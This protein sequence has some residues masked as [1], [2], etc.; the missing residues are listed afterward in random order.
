[1]LKFEE[2][3]DLKNYRDRIELMRSPEPQA[4]RT[5]RDVPFE[6]PHLGNQIYLDHAANTIYMSSLIRSYHERLVSHTNAAT[7]SLFS[8]PHSQSQSGQ[9]TGSLVDATREKILTYLLDTNSSEY[10]LVFV[11]NATAGLK[12][13]GECVRPGCLAYLADNHTSAI[14]MRELTESN[15]DVYCISSNNDH[16]DNDNDDDNLIF[17]LINKSHAENNM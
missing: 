15:A 5:T 4:N 8:N 13:L 3:Y 6:F 16:S 2:N 1:M 11:A 12:L 7:W 9:Y 17:K 10:D 14:G